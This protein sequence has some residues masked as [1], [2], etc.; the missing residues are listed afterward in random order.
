MWTEAGRKKRYEVAFL[1][2][3]RAAA[4]VLAAAVFSCGSLGAVTEV[5]KCPRGCV[6]TRVC[7]W[8]LSL[9][10]AGVEHSL[11]MGSRKG[12]YAALGECCPAVFVFVDLL[13]LCSHFVSDL[14]RKDFCCLK[15]IV[16]C[17]IHLKTTEK[18]NYPSSDACLV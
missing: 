9:G 13:C 2:E 10:G 5:P 17:S 18:T 1:A 3:G 7:A 11:G 15:S 14:S 16:F 12:F 4:S 6:L 8:G